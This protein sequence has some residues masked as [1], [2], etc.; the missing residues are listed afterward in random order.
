MSCNKVVVTSST[1]RVLKLLTHLGDWVE[2]EAG[3]GG[4][5]PAFVQR[6][7]ADQRDVFLRF[8]VLQARL[9]SLETVLITL[10][11]AKI[12][13]FTLHGRHIEEVALEQGTASALILWK[14]ADP[15]NLWYPPACFTAFGKA[16]EV[17]VVSQAAAVAELLALL[18]DS[19]V[20]ETLMV[21][22]AWPLNYF[23]KA[24]IDGFQSED[25]S[26]QYH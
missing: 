17:V 4:G 23:E 12:E 19:V 16:V 18:S 15:R 6:I 9:Q 13:H 1:A 7:A 11:A 10:T 24:H 2:V 8:A 22:S 5:T 20:K 3:Y 14:P 26:T 25:V 21:R